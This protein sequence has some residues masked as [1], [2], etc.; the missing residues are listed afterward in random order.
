MYCRKCGTELLPEQTVCSNCGEIQEPQAEQTHKEKE[1]SKYTENVKRVNRLTLA[2][3]AITIVLLVTLFFVPIFKYSIDWLAELQE[4]NP[5]GYASLNLPEPSGSFSL[6]DETREFISC[7]KSEKTDNITKGFV[8]S[9]T[10]V[11]VIFTDIFILVMMISSLL[12]TANAL[13]DIENETLL[14]YTR[15]QK[16]GLTESTRK[17]ERF[18]RKQTSILLVIYIILDILFCKL[19]FKLFGDDIYSYIERKMFYLSGV[20]VAIALPVVLLI[21][22]I[23]VEKKRKKEIKAMLVDITKKEYT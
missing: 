16:T 13:R 19:L 4:Y 3:Q 2:T 1:Y 14:T 20:S 21:A 17:R 10:L 6:F 7:V 15:M 11:V 9:L 5:V 18:A 22:Y 23:V 12:K 8:A